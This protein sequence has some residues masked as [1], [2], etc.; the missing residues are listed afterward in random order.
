MLR[1]LAGGVFLRPGKSA[2]LVEMNFDQCYAPFP[3][4]LP[5]LCPT[6]M[7]IELAGPQWAW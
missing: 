1:L 7:C 3:Q 2:K 6:A 5:S 4:H